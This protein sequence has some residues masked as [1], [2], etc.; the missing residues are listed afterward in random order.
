M[1][2]VG[3]RSVGGAVLCDM[4]S[5]ANLFS[6]IAEDIA[7][8]SSRITIAM[9]DWLKMFIMVLFRAITQIIDHPIV[10]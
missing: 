10:G 2:R 4:V 1:G 7:H 8:E 6:Y 5:D 9:A 3:V